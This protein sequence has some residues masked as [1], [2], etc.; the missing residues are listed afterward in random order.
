[1]METMA[2]GGLLLGGPTVPAVLIALLAAALG[3]V[4]TL[5]GFAVL[6][7]LASTDA[8][9]VYRAMARVAARDGVVTRRERALLGSVARATRMAPA[10]VARVESEV[11]GGGRVVFL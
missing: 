2:A 7:G 10:L 5:L 8:A 1:M 4:A 6:R 11:F 3:F 9:G